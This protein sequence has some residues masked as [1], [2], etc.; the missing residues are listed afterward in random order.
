MQRI[1]RARRVGTVG[2]CCGVGLL[3]AGLATAQQP[4][5][6][7]A[8]EQ[9]QQIQRQQQRQIPG[10]Q[11]RQAHSQTGEKQFCL[12]TELIGMSVK[13]QGE[14]EVGQVQNL[15][16]N[17]EGQVQYLAVS[18]SGQGQ[19]D[20]ATS[21]IPGQ[22]QGQ[23]GQQ[24]RAGQERPGLE[25]PGQAG[26][27]RPGAAQNRAQAQGAGGQLTLVPW[28]MAELHSGATPD[29]SY[30]T[31]NIEKDRLTSAPSF[32]QQQLTSEQGQAQ[33]VAQVDQF[34]Q[35]RER[36]GAARPELEQ[37]RQ[38]GTDQPQQRDREIPPQRQD[39]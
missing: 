16:I 26:Q 21:R 10:Q 38:R 7:R 36:R 37:E 39:N 5:A 23:P 27:E 13:A 2:L 11:Q 32:S 28:E 33:I 3:A 15:I 24:D 12:S 9:Q 14:E 31:L 17:R 29:Q 18:T 34:F 22:Q 8:A 30:V 6:E 35:I 19:S 20:R 4:A 25:R 1:R